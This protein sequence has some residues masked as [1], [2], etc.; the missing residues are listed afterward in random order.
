MTSVPK[1]A[2][3]CFQ[4]A[5]LD[6]RLRAGSEATVGA[7]APA[8]GEGGQAGPSPNNRNPTGDR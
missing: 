5:G 8:S 7:T 4:V 3:A 6:N 1:Q 2:A